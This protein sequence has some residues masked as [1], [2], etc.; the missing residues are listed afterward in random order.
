MPTSAME[1]TKQL[2]ENAKHYFLSYQNVQ[3]SCFR[4]LDEL[5]RDEYKVS[6]MA[7]LNGWNSSMTIQEILSQLETTFGRPT[8]SIVFNNNTRFT[9][10]F[11]P[12]DTPE[13]LFRRVEEC[14]E[15]AI[16]GGAA[17]TVNQIM[18][19]TMYLLLQAGIFPTREFEAW[20]TVVGKTWPVLKTFVQA[21]YQRRLVA[22]GL[23]NTSGQQG[24]AANQNA[25]QAFESNDESSVDT[26]TTNIAPTANTTGST[27][28]QTYNASTV[29]DELAAAIRTIA[30]NQQALY[31]H[32]APLSQQ[33]AALSHQDSQRQATFPH[34]PIT[35]LTLP[36]FGTARV[37]QP[38][39]YHGGCVAQPGGYQQGRGATVAQP[40][41]FSQGRGY[42]R[43]RG[44]YG[45]RPNRGGRGRTAFADYVPSGRG[46][47]YSA[48]GGANTHR[49]FQSNLV[50]THN[51]W[52]VCYSCGFDV[53]DTHD[54]M[55]C[56]MDWRKPG[57]DVYF[58]RAN[59][60]Q[61]L[62]AGC[63][64]CTRGMHKSILPGQA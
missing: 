11:D 44:R 49:P 46:G 42:G 48:T 57:H 62:D 26:T 59:A 60:Q 14:Q 63:N 20:D 54:S 64:A 30:D 3:R 28:G 5:V 33:M 21:A 36:A 27:L 41:G 16:L 31:Q 61:K 24:Y 37:A 40:G 12:R 43:G 53:E 39:G 4:L 22:T 56:H 45:R 1:V 52:N 51:N 18:G 47:A 23:R 58:T 15:I 38:G 13:N 32:I 7:G 34:P 9:S 50:K 2:W 35:Q 19:N 17:Y 6:N 25:F 55:S 10:P 8:S 29:P